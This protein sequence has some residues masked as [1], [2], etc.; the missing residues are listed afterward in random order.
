[1]EREGGRWR[2]EEGLGG[3]VSPGYLQLLVQL[4]GLQLSV[5]GH[6]LLQSPLALVQ[7]SL[8]PPPSSIASPVHEGTP[9]NS[10]LPPSLPL[11]SPYLLEC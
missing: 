1:M 4:R 6:G 2:G 10:G 8:Q 11:P 5:G 3:E 9:L 7:L